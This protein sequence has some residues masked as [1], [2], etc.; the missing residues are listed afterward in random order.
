EPKQ[1]ES[2]IADAKKRI[3][4]VDDHDANVLGENRLDVGLC[5]PFF[6]ANSSP[7]KLHLRMPC[8]QL[9]P[10]RPVCFGDRSGRTLESARLEALRAV[11]EG[12]GPRVGGRR[13]SH[14]AIL[15]A[16]SSEILPVS[17]VG[18]SRILRLRL[19]DV[20]RCLRPDVL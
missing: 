10:G 17:T 2:P 16:P 15:I 1:D 5:R 14:P 7:D 11:S 18:T 13:E 6:S 8:R 20:A 9:V 4:Q 12:I 19:F 3:R